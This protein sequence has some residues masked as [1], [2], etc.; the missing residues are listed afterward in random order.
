[1]RERFRHAQGDGTDLLI[2]EIPGPS[3]SVWALVESPAATAAGRQGR[4][5][6][7][8]GDQADVVDDCAHR[9]T[10]RLGGRVES[11]EAV[12]REAIEPS[13]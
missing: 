9:L 10:A 3:G 4:I 13:F 7:E 1:M 11:W 8:G 2:G 12:I 6:R 5:L